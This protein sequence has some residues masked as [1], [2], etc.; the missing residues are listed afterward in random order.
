MPH[1]EGSMSCRS[2]G[3]FRSPIKRF[4]WFRGKRHPKDMAEPEVEAF[5]YNL[6]TQRVFS[7]ST[8]KEAL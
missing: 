1:G 7:A 8:Q 6:A 3:N 4:V 2:S 5:L